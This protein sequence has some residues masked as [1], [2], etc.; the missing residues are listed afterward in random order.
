M[1]L[2]AILIESGSNNGNLNLSGVI[3]VD[4]RSEY[5][6][7]FLIAGFGDDFCGFVDFEH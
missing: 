6:V 1:P 2:V 7:R 3:L 5:D 4:G